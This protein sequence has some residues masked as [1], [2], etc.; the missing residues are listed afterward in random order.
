M[1]NRISRA[2]WFHE[3]KWCV[4]MHFLAAPASSSQGAEIEP[5]TW[6]RKVNAFDVAGLTRQLLEAR[7]GYFI[8]TLGQN[9]RRRKY[10]PGHNV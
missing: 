2:E 1:N 5:E 9:S 6:N 3:A 4:F 7:A 8:L 10:T